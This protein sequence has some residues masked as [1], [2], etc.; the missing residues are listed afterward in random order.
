MKKPTLISEFVEVSIKDNFLKLIKNIKPDLILSVHPNFNA[1]VLNI[2]NEFN[3]KIPFVTLIADL[4]SISPLWAD[5]RADYII[6]PTKEAEEKCIEFGV[7]PSKL[8]VMGFPVRARFYKNMDSDIS[9]NN[10]DPARPLRCLIM[11]GGEGVGNMSR[12]AKIILSNYNS[13]VAIIAGRNK[14]LKRRLELSLSEKFSGRVEIYGFTNNIQELMCE[15]DIAVTRGSPNVAMEAVSCNTPLIITGALPG[16][17]EGNPSY[18]EKYNL[19][20]TC[21][22][23]RFLKQI[24]DRLLKNNGSELNAIKESQRK[25]RNPNIAA[26]IVK[27]LIDIK[28]NSEFYMQ[29]QTKKSYKSIKI[30]KP[31]TI[32]KNKD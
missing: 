26:N 30:L 29:D 24:I 17:E 13:K 6:C 22:D 12:I 16:Q 31:G 7:S 4:V 8:K 5:P 18:L 32:K 25:Y 19:G 21:N 2:L 23:I 14:I 9:R 15:S 28:G 1:S 20:V 10:Y 27:F 11:S 3:I